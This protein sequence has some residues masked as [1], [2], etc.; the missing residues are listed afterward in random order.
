MVHLLK[1]TAFLLS[2][3]QKHDLQLGFKLANKG[4]KMQML[5]LVW[6]TGF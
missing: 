5:P 4:E 3:E 1:T 6:Y 2:K